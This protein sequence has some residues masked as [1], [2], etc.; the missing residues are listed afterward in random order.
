MHKPL[1][2]TCKSLHTLAQICIS[3]LCSSSIEPPTIPWVVFC[4]HELC[5]YYSLCQTYL[6][7]HF[8]YVDHSYFSMRS[9]SDVPPSMKL[10]S[11][12]LFP[13]VLIAPPYSSNSI[14]T[15]RS[16][17]IPS[18]SN[19]HVVDSFDNLVWHFF[20]FLNPSGLHI[21]SISSIYMDGIHRNCFTSGIL[22][23]KALYLTTA[24]PLTLSPN[25][26]I[27]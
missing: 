17:I 25:V 27:F 9:K 14:S 21:Y 20:D 26:T 18:V 19:I 15:S 16:I 13:N 11:I 10:F 12:S 2:I 4:V 1:F 7:L 6:P 8:L 3:S 23:S 5:T 22:N 24:S